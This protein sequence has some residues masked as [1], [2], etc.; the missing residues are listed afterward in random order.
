MRKFLEGLMGPKIDDIDWEGEFKVPLDFQNGVVNW[1]L[2]LI[3]ALLFGVGV[4]EFYIPVMFIGAV[5]FGILLG[6]TK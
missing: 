5:L 4:I 6:R 2:F 1:A 3:G